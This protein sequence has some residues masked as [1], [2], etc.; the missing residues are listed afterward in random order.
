MTSSIGTG[1]ASVAA[2]AACRTLDC[3][4]RISPSAIMAIETVVTC[5]LG[6]P[7][8]MVQSIAMPAMMRTRGWEKSW[9]EISSLRLASEAE[10]VTIIP[11]ATEMSS[12]GIWDIR[13]SPTV[14]V[15]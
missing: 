11:V 8:N 14:E 1:P 2:A 5:A 12:A 9:L 4:I 13:P 6:K 10:R 7:I 3:R 15:E